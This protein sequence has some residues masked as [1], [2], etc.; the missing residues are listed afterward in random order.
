MG[1]SPW[2]TDDE[3]RF[4]CKANQIAR[5][6]PA[7]GPTVVRSPG[8]RLR[9]EQRQLEVSP[10]ASGS[11][12]MKA[13]RSPSV[14][15]SASRTTRLARAT[16]FLW[17]IAKDEAHILQRAHG[18]IGIDHV[19]GAELDEGDAIDQGL[20][21][22]FIHGSDRNRERRCCFEAGAA[23]PG[24]APGRCSR[25]N[26]AVSRACLARAQWVCLD[27]RA[28]TSRCRGVSDAAAAPCLG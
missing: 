12:R 22:R 10:I 15:L 4:Y 24:Q 17:E 21:D 5:W 26:A 27:V 19:I 3:M 13:A 16:C 6:A 11:D 2:R 1:G 20:K 28:C 14:S 9:Q 23:S 7:G 25:A 18:S 8:C